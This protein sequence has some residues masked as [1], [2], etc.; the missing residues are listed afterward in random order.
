METTPQAHSSGGGFFPATAGSYLPSP[1]PSNFSDTHS[2]NTNLLPQP[3][4][5][6]L[7]PGSK[8]ESAFIN[9]VDAAL[10]GVSRKYT[11]KFPSDEEKQNQN[12]GPDDVIGYSDVEQLVIDLERI[13]GLVW[14]SGT[15]IIAPVFLFL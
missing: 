11:K 5:Q 14:V 13:V 1:A 9:Y 2:R 6:P 4:S 15:C 7:K 12:I 8:R 10:L 3:R